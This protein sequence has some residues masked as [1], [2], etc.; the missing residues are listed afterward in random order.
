MDL[1]QIQMMGQTKEWFVWERSRQIR[2]DRLI[3]V[4]G[5]ELLRKEVHFEREKIEEMVVKTIQAK[6]E[7]FNK[8]L[9]LNMKSN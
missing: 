9:T 3:F 2:E 5:D 7:I 4:G 8:K 6:L 1:R